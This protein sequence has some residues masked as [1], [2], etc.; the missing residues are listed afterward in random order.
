MLNCPAMYEEIMRGHQRSDELLEDF[1]DS[2]KFK[3]RPLFGSHHNTL[4]IFL[5]FDECKLCNP[6][7][8]FRKKHKISCYYYTI[9]NICPMYQST[10][11]AIQLLCLVEAP[12]LGEYGHDKILEPAIKDIKQLEKGCAFNTCEGLVKFYGTI[13]TVSGDN[14]V[15]SAVAG[16]KESS[17]AYR[18]CRQCLTTKPEIQLKFHEKYFDL[19]TPLTHQDHCQLLKDNPTIRDHYSMALGVNRESILN[20]LVYF[21]VADE[22]VLPD[23]MHDMLEGYLPYKTKLMLNYFIS[24]GLFSNDDINNLMSNF[25]YGFE[26]ISIPSPLTSTILQSADKTRIGQTAS[27]MWTLG[28]MLPVMIGHFIPQDDEHWL[29]YIQLLDIVDLIFAPTVNP[30]T[31]GYLEVL[32]EENLE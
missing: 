5:F 13:A 27:Q 7:G 32:I 19:R 23:L 20:S 24:I 8:S 2:P 10:L 17:A 4:Q 31:P 3:Y 21:D 14:P 26:S 15:S 1:C 9:G 22:C 11:E 25:D 18:L 30:E 16:F 6:L 29:H 28:R 12:L